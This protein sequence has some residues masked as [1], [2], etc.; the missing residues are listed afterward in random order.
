MGGAI[1]NM[2]GDV[3]IRAST[4]TQNSATGGADAVPD[5]QLDPAS[6]LGGAVF[7]LSG[8]VEIVGSTLAGNVASDRGSS[9]YSTVADAVTE[10]AAVRR[11]ATRSS[12]TPADLRI[13][14]RRSSPASA[15]ANSASGPRTRPSAISTWSSRWPPRGTGNDHGLGS[16]CRSEARAPGQQRRGD[17]DPR[18][19]SRQSRGRRRLCL[20]SR[21]RPARARPAERF[22]GDPERGRRLRHR[23]RRAPGAPAA[24]LAPANGAPARIGSRVTARFR[25]RRTATIVRR[26]RVRRLPARAKVVI[27]CARK[28]GNCPFRR[29]TRRYS[30]ATTVDRF[31]R[32]FK[33]R[34]LRPRT[35]ITI[36]V[37]APGVIGLFVR[38]TTRAGKRPRRIERCL[39][40]GT[41][42]PVRC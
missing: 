9:I 5:G 22:P 10:R 2:Q 12:R 41:T 16:H 20:R 33:R 31:E 15:A 38:Y 30:A 11:S 3:T 7:N 4:L 35:R 6:G 32:L 40:P 39:P 18:P 34:R 19:R 36:R 17:A 27:S 13:S 23:L 25:L 29:K 24:G 42:K 14:S 8:S 26:L 28:R 21:Q 37:T 1:F